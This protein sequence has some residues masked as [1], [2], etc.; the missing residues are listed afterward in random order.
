MKYSLL[1]CYGLVLFA[2]QVFFANGCA[3][4][5]PSCGDGVKNGTETDVD[6]GGSCLKCPDSQ[7][8][9]VDTD[10]R[11]GGCLGTQCGAPINRPSMVS[12]SKG[13]FNMGSPTTEAQRDLD[14]AQHKV[15]ISSSF[16]MMETEVTQLQFY[17]IMSLRPSFFQGDDYP[18]E[19]VTWHMAIN[20]ANKLS[21]K[22]G[23]PSCYSFQGTDVVWIDGP[24]CMG[25]RLPT[26]A[27]WEYASKQAQPSIY[28]GSDNIDKVAWYS[29]NSTGSSHAVKTKEPNGLSLFDLSGNVYEWVWDN[30]LDRYE[31][32]PAQDPLGPITGTARVVRGGSWGDMAPA[33]RVANR[34]NASASTAGNR[35]GFRLVR[36]LP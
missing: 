12:I 24:R 25:Y 2:L 14:E 8:C 7:Q 18:V 21:S 6:C 27:E 29:Q 11:S 26:E 4:E 3:A 22:E 15:I 31:T 36:T 32:L 17:N 33:S 30:Y 13:E 16:A 1:S 35:L 28:A 9:I 34:G 19:Q 23:R 5:F 10:C 20:Y